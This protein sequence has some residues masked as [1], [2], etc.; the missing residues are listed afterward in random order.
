MR[1]P[2]WISSVP[3]AGP[4]YNPISPHYS[5]REDSRLVRWPLVSQ[6]RC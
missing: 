4:R 3:G 5:R 6:A 2:D 1:D